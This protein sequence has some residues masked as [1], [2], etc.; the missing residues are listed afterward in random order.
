MITIRYKNVIIN[1][2]DKTGH[3]ERMLEADALRLVKAEHAEIVQEEAMMDP[4]E[5]RPLPPPVSTS[6][7][8]K[9]KKK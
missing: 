4:G 5:R 9:R 8:K 2:V 6:N 7:N 3:I 1:G